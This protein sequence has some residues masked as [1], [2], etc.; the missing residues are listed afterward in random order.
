MPNESRIRS[1]DDPRVARF[2]NTT[3]PHR[4]EST[5]HFLV[6][7]ENVVVRFLASDFECEQVLCAEHKVERIAPLLKPD[8]E[9]LIADRRLV[10][11]IVGFKFHSGVMA[12]G[13]RKAEG[14]IDELFRGKSANDDV[15]LLVLPEI[16]DAAN[17]GAM[18]RTAAA[19]GCDG[20]IL[21]ER[22]RDPFIRQT[23]RVSMGTIFF[24]PIIRSN[25]IRADLVALHERHG[26]ELWATVLDDDAQLLY[27]AQRSHRL[28]LLLGNEGPGLERDVVELCQRKVTIPMRRGTDSLNVGASCAVFLYHFTTPAHTPTP[29]ES[30]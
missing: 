6:E 16:T 15:T 14:R 13:R 28:G 20:V 11:E 26:V 27:Q 5:T 4:V 18:I 9:L 17:I 25:D 21:G 7:S 12:I 24:I 10:N 29:A 30:V 19:F 22:C 8:T 23:I 2:V 3:D 1:V